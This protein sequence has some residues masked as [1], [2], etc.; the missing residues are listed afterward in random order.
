MNTKVVTLTGGSG[1]VGQILRRGLAERGYEIRVFDRLRG[2]LVDLLRRRYLGTSAPSLGVGAAVLIRIIQKRLEPLFLRTGLLRPSPDDILQS[3][4]QV[5]ERLRGS[6]AV[7]HLA[8]IPHPRMPGATPEDFQRLNYEG[9]VNVYQAAL[10]AG[11]KKFIFASSGQ[12][13]GINAPVRIDQ[14]PLLESNHCP[15]LEEGQNLYGWL[16]LEVERYLGQQAASRP[17]M[18]TISLR[19]EFPGLRS[20]TPA[21]LYIST[22]VDNLVAGVANAL[23]ASPNFAFEAFNLADPSVDPNIVD[24]QEFLR[25]QWPDVPNYTAGNQTLLSIEKARALL[26]YRPIQAGRYLS[27]FLAGP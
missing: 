11:V 5:A 19:L 16:K 12:V 13:Y 4:G 17:S 7:I 27:V 6:H 24:I 2:P 10:E 8:G 21:N 20:T 18:Q 3:Q 23:E 22:S 15:T 9:S 26:G 14:F 1:F 25:R